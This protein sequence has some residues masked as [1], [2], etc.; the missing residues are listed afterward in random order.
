MNRVERIKRG[1][2]SILDYE[3]TEKELE[4][5]FNSHYEKYPHVQGFLH[6]LIL[7]LLRE[8]DEN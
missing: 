4:L 6:A 7:H 1:M 5:L 8:K 2:W 3:L